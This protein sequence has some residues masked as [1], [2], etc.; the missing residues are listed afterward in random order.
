M[1]ETT[2]N[3]F[4]QGQQDSSAG[5]L[6]SFPTAGIENP[7]NTTEGKR[8]LFSSYFPSTIHHD[9]EVTEAET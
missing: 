3:P 1:S 7:S 4:E 8:G 2:S 5:V 6:A 9:R